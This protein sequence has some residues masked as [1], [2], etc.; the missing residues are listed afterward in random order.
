MKTPYAMG[1]LPDSPDPRDFTFKAPRAVITPVKFDISQLMPPVWDQGRIGQCT[2]VAI[3]CLFEHCHGQED[4]P[5][6]SLFLY[7][8]EREYERS[9]PFD[10]GAQ[11]RTGMKM[12]A[13]NGMAESKHYGDFS[14]Q[15]KPSI[16]AMTNALNYQ[17]IA[18]YR[19]DNN[20]EIPIEAAL[21][22]GRPV[23]FGATIFDEI[24]RLTKSKTI[25]TLPR[26]GS[27]RIGGHAMVIVGYDKI[28]KLYLVRNSWGDSFGNKGH[29]HMPYDYIHN[30][31]L[32]CDFWMI[33]STE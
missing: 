28:T 33:E 1:W 13:A 31:N 30:P 12:L 17:S 23:V 19:L 2:A 3:R 16:K 14:W 21:A 29:F 15:S 7:Y 22:Q 27:K 9:L 20:N 18:Y 10:N 32:C 11:I 25:L 5:H 4:G 8:L 6:S 24:N 26:R